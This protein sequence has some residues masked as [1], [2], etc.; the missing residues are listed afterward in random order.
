V[1]ASFEHSAVLETLRSL[2]ARGW[3]VTWVDPGGDGVVRPE[4]VEAALRPDTALATVMA[5]NNEVGTVQPVTEIGA[6]LAARGIPFHCD[7]VQALGKLE[8]AHPSAW[9]AA[10]AAFSA[11]KING[12]KGVGALY[13][14]K[15]AALKR[16]LHGGPHERGLRGGTENVPGIVGFG[17][18]A[19]VWAREGT[20]ERFRLAALRDGLEAALRHRIPGLVVNGEGVERVPNTLHVTLPGCASDLLVMALDMRGVA[21]SAGSACASGAARQSHVLLAMGKGKEA[22]SSSLRLSLGRGNDEAEI[23][24][25]ADAIAEAARQIRA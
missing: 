7:A 8:R 16:I 5:A 6:L 3:S 1:A 25:V 20:A 15:G 9:Q 22:A 24:A 17:K 10:T 11:H 13:A 23:P 21:V 19:E 12:P 4:A 2:E 18:A 14:R